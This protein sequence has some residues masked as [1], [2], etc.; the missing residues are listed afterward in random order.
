MLG[1]SIENVDAPHPGTK[2]RPGQG[3][4][5]RERGQSAGAIVA[6]LLIA[7][8]C[9]RSSPADKQNVLQQCLVGLKELGCCLL[10]PSRLMLH[11]LLSSFSWDES[12]EFLKNA[13]CDCCELRFIWGKMKTSA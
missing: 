4:R 3:V 1:V 5:E 11:Y 12:V 8:P 13:Q 9:Q 10:L 6:T 7:A 2:H